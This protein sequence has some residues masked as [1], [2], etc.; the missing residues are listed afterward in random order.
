MPSKDFPASDETVFLE[1]AFNRFVKDCDEQALHNKTTDRAPEELKALLDV[2]TTLRETTT[3]L[4]GQL[5]TAS[6]HHQATYDKLREEF[7]AANEKLRDGL[8]AKH[9]EE[10]KALRET[11]TAL[12]RRMDD[13]QKINTQLQRANKHHQTA[14]EELREVSGDSEGLAELKK[15][16]H[17]TQDVQKEH[18]ACL[19]QLI[20]WTKNRMNKLLPPTF[21]G[22][23]A[24]P[25]S[26]QLI[27]C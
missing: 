23:Y 9:S 7:Q 27:F 8:Q 17:Q 10:L 19:W 4:Q 12:Q 3:A 25:A 2:T 26:G 5:Q 13:A 14:I 6:N 18:D 22:T 24:L 1:A 15:D 21:H 16:L 11:I 20:D